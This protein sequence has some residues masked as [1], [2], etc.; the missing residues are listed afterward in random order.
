MTRETLE[1]YYSIASRIQAIDEEIRILYTPKLG[2]HSENIGAGRASVRKA[3]NPT[4]ETAMRIVKLK[5]TLEAERMHLLDLA[6]EI[7]AWLDDLEDPE[8]EAIVRWHYLLRCNWKI[9]NLKVYGYPDYWYSRKRIERYFEKN[10]RRNQ[11][12]STVFY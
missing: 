1:E 5:E 11:T 9:T 10:G 3:G 2:G 7:E 12:T 8:I 6:E 4:E